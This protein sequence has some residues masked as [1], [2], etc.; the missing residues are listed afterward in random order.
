ME[1]TFPNSTYRPSIPNLNLPLISCSFEIFH[2]ANFATVLEN[3]RRALKNL[4]QK[5]EGLVENVTFDTRE[6]RSL[7]ALLAKIQH[8][9]IFHFADLLSKAELYTDPL[10]LL[11]SLSEDEIQSDLQKMTAQ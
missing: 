2:F 5:F 6:D 9:E 4:P 8:R 10:L 1:S 7:F 3:W 11:H